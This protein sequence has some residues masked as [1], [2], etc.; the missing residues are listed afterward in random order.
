MALFKIKKEK[1]KDTVFE[2]KLN[3]GNNI[4]VFGSNLKGFHA[5]GAA[6]AA[7][8]VWGAELG[9]GEGI[10]G[11]S[12]ALPTMDE[13][14]SPLPLEVIKQKVE[15]FIKVA[16]SMPEKTFLITA[17]GCGIAGYNAQQIAPLFSNTPGN[18]LL[19]ASWMEFTTGKFALKVL[20]KPTDLDV[21]LGAFIKS[22]AKLLAEVYDAEDQP[23]TENKKDFDVPDNATE[24]QKTLCK[25]ITSWCVDRKLVSTGGCKVFY[26]AE[27]WLNRGQ[28]YGRE[29]TLIIAHDG[30][31]MARVCN[32]DYEAYDLVD[33]FAKFLET[34]GYYMEQ[35]TS[36]YSAIYPL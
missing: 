1:M 19:P 33:K 25:L 9:V 2:A 21:D 12:Y 11:N 5:G 23:S 16:R 36:W 27:D 28:V 17:V 6:K 30:G 35:C 14:L 20:S 13:T 29:A 34:H 18:C 3:D 8:E 26:T 22:I 15:A 7:K 10:T 4:F 31:D 24:E 32:I